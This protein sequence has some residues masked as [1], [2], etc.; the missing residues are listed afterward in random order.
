[1]ANATENNK[2]IA[3]N[4][5]LLYVR[6]LVMMAVTLYTSRVVLAALGVEDFGIYNVV[7]GVVSMFSVLSGSFTT[8]ISRCHNCRDCRIVVLK[9][10]DEHPTRPNM[11]RKLGIS[12]LYRDIYPKSDQHTIQCRHY[13]TRKN[14]GVCLHQCY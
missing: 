5:L 4:T 9:C 10:P 6:M 14:V 8:S 3:K 13:R 2:R 7:G 11:G 1:M 12:V